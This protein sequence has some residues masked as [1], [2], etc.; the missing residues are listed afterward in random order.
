MMDLKQ[1]EEFAGAFWYRYFKAVSDS[2]WFKLFSLA[3]RTEHPCLAPYN[4]HPMTE[5]HLD[6]F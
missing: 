6:C 5:S 2:I 3:G 1:F 4:E